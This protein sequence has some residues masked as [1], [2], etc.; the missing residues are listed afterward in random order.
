MKWV[1]S[2][3]Q[4]ASKLENEKPDEPCQHGYVNHDKQEDTPARQSF[5]HGP[6]SNEKYGENDKNED[7]GVG[8]LLSHVGLPA[9]NEPVWIASR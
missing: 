8:N 1:F 7:E 9:R 4:A 5:F 2:L 3:K 6:H